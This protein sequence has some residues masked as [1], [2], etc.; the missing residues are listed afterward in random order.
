MKYRIKKHLPY[1]IGLVALVY[2]VILSAKDYTWVFL[3]GDSGDWLACANWWMV[4]QPYGS[5][6]YIILGRL[7]GLLPGSQ[8]LNLTILL[9]CL[10]SAITVGLVYLTVKHLTDSSKEASTASTGSSRSSFTIPLISSL[11]LLG[12]AVFLSQ[13]TVLEEYALATMFL[14]AAIYTYVRG[15]KVLTMTL[16]GLGTAVHI[17]V[18]ILLLA[19]VIAEWKN[20]KQWLKPAVIYGV[21]VGVSYSFTLLLMAMDTPR[22]L[23]GGL[24][25]YSV[26]FYWTATTG[27]ILGQLS[28]FEAPTRLL[29]LGALVLASFGLALIPI[30]SSCRR[31]ITKPTIL[32]SG[33]ILITLWYY[34]TNLDPAAW[35]FVAFASPALSVLC[36]LGLHKLEARAPKNSDIGLHRL[37]SHYM[38]VVAV[39]AVALVLINGVFLNANTLTNENPMASTYRRELQSLPD[40]SIV[41]TTPGAYGLGLFYTMSEG[42]DLVPLVYHYLDSWEFTDYATWLRDNHEILV[43]PSTLD[44]IEANL[45]TVPIYFAGSPNVDYPI[46]PAL[47]L[48]DIGRTFVK[49]VKGLTGLP[50]LPEFREVK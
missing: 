20:W 32:L 36:G 29:Y 10:P 12:S 21:I 33:I 43:L 48:E 38:Y 23:A 37:N 1:L 17:F 19:W 24:N 26:Q 16:L 47:E 6:L 8:P 14:T 49:R 4:P 15:N 41:L 25:F 45:K 40:D 3:S 34:G 13:S 11:V 5:P 42:K 2:Y 27:A 18:G 22:L 31:P 7:I 28:L 50:P 9:S 46:E 44:T 30:C 35:T 39:G